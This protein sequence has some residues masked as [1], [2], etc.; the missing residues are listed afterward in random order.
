MNKAVKFTLEL[1]GFL[2]I[3]LLFFVWYLGYRKNNPSVEVSQ[4][5]ESTQVLEGS[6]D[7]RLNDY[8]NSFTVSSSDY[9]GPKY[10]KPVPLSKKSNNYLA[11][12]AGPSAA[13]K[14]VK[15]EVTAVKVLRNWKG[16]HRDKTFTQKCFERFAN[17]VNELSD[18]YGLYP[19]VFMSRI[20]AYSYSFV[21][22]PETDPVDK[23]FTAMKQPNGK[24]R[25]RFRNSFESLKAYAIVNAGEITRLSAEGALAKHERAWTMQKIID[26][27][28]YIKAL[29]KDR[30]AAYAGVLGTA[31]KISEAV[32]Y[33]K[34][35]VGEAVKMAAKVDDVVKERRA[36]KAGYNTW[37]EYLEDLPEEEKHAQEENADA[38]VTAISKKKAFNLKRRVAAKTKTDN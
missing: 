26:N 31:N 17:M 15:P 30:E 34:E 2:I 3:G 18:E 9:S 4:N 24:G 22:N 14:V 19:E 25:A 23:N 33:E 7:E 8:D 35:L 38:V 37:E 1:A 5:P 13:A 36:Q 21:L 20:I 27:N 28:T 12:N 10:Q 16:V 11:L 32:K 29:R 6:L